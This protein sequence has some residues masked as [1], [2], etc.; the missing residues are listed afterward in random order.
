MVVA[1]VSR[2]HQILLQSRVQPALSQIGNSVLGI[3][4]R[5]QI[6]V[7]GLAFTAHTTAVL[8]SV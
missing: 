4:A 7:Y 6:D 1:V 5:A 3:S 2:L 8:L